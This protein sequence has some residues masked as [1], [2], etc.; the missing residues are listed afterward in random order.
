[1][2]V[3]TWGAWGERWVREYFAGELVGEGDSGER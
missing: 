1:V 3:L 2:V